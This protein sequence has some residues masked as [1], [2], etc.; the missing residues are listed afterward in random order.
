MPTLSE[1]KS[2][3]TSA[4]WTTGKRGFVSSIH[5]NSRTSRCAFYLYCRISARV[6]D[7]EIERPAIRLVIFRYGINFIYCEGSF[8]A[9]VR[10]EHQ[11]DVVQLH[12]PMADFLPD[13][14]ANVPPNW[15]QKGI[16]KLR[17]VGM[18]GLERLEE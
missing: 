18:P 6:K 1:C 17:S 7:F 10:V 15:R 13:A 5:R 16:F 11:A 4:F 14:K 8:N 2:V 12:S 3:G 9:A